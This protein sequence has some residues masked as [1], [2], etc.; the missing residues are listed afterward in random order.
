MGWMGRGIEHLIVR[1]FPTWTCRSCL[2]CCIR[3]C[4]TAPLSRMARSGL[5][6]VCVLLLDQ[7][8]A[9]QTRWTRRLSV[10][11]AHSEMLD[12]LGR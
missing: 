10:K 12:S 3:A 5:P 2:T 6:L 4:M 11:P 7:C 8:R 1:T 9:V